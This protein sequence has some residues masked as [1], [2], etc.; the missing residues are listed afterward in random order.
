[1]IASCSSTRFAALA[2][3]RR[4]VRPRLPG[5]DLRPAELTTPARIIALHATSATTTSQMRRGDFVGLLDGVFGE[6]PRHD[7]IASSTS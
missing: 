3:L 6:L 1:V 5:R 4:R 2:A 7:A